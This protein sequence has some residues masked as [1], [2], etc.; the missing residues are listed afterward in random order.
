MLNYA[1]QDEYAAYAE[2]AGIIRN[3]DVKAPYD[4]I[5]SAEAAHLDALRVLT[6]TY[7][8][9]FPEDPSADHVVIPE[10][11]LM[12]AQTGITAEIN[13]IAMYDRFL[14]YELPEDIQR[15]FEALRDASVNHLAAFE[16]QVAKLTQTERRLSSILHEL[17]A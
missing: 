7:G 14:N 8:I 12:A 13:N 9:T 3:Y 6:L 4:N 5:I 15:V 2:Y 10:S 17:S 16:R 1:V 11:L